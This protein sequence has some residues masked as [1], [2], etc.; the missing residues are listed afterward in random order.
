MWRETRV[1]HNVNVDLTYVV[2]EL[3]CRACFSIMTKCTGRNTMA[4]W[5]QQT[6]CATRNKLEGFIFK[7]S[8]LTGRPLVSMAGSYSLTDKSKMKWHGIQMFCLKIIGLPK[9][10]GFFNGSLKLAFCIVC[11][12][13]KDWLCFENMQAKAR[14]YRLGWLPAITHK[15]SP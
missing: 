6:L 14:G 9:K 13:R 5:P 12:S 3:S 1:R 11:E 10:S 7:L 2:I 15:Q 4:L 8:I